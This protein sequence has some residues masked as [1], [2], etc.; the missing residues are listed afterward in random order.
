MA[1]H[2]HGSH[3]GSG[4]NVIRH[5]QRV[6]TALFPHSHNRKFLVPNR[7]I[8]PQIVS[9]A[10][11]TLSTTFEFDRDVSGGDE[12]GW[13]VTL[14]GTP[15]AIVSVINGAPTDIVVNYAGGIIADDI[16]VTYDG[17]GVWADDNGAPLFPIDQSGVVV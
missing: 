14:N 3:L 6:Q 7:H 8:G 12:V 11:K 9:I 2:T 1:K 10:F 17:T 5:K 13:A 4:V 16:R 15:E